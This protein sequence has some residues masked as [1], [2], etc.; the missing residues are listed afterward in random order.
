M[1]K[2]SVTGSVIHI[3]EKPFFGT[4]KDGGEW[5]SK[6]LAI[7]QDGKYG[8]KIAFRL[9]N[10]RAD[11]LDALKLKD[12]VTVSF[13]VESRQV[14]EKWYTNLTAYNVDIV[15]VVKKEDIEFKADRVPETEDHKQ[16][17]DDL[18]F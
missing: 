11:M 13:N 5:K 12:Q 3:D 18:P 1:E 9:F 6:E 7:K 2:L 17:P 15:T 10:D 8:K 14:G 16:E 4:R